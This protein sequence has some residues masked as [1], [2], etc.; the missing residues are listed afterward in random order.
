MI[1]SQLSSVRVNFDDEVRDLLILS[2]LPEIWNGLAMATSNSV[3]RSSTLNFDDVF[4]AILSEE[5]RQK[6]SGET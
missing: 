1:T 4:G 6:I 5:M 2:S 3:S